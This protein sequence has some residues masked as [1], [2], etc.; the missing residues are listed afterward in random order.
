[1]DLDHESDA[2]PGSFRHGPDDRERPLF[3]V[4]LQ[5]F[6]GGG[7]RIEL[8]GV[9]AAGNHLARPFAEVV[10]PI[11]APV[12]T[13]G[14]GQERRLGAAADQAIDRLPGGLADD[15]PHGDFGRR[16]RRH[17]SRAAL[18]LVA[19][20]RADNRFD[21]ERV[22]ADDPGGHPLVQQNLDCLLLPFKRPLADADHS[23]IGGEPHEQVV[24]LAGI[25]EKGL[26]FLDLHDESMFLTIPIV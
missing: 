22:L 25:G 21:V 14:V 26:E 17:H 23:G 11:A 2:R 24:A 16:N 10:R 15:V 18:I 5:R 8:H 1:M 4:R 13:I 3:L 19:D 7:E 6:P 20:H 12:P 9:I